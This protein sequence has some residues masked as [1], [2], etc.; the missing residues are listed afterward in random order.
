MFR[1]Q[2]WQRSL[3]FEYPFTISKGTKTH[4]PT[5]IVELTF[6]GIKGYGESPAISYYNISTEKMAADLESKRKF[7]ESYNLT[8]PK[9]FWHFLHHLFPDN[10][11]LVCALDMAAWDIYG[12]LNGKPLYAIWNLDPQNAPHT[13]YTIGIDDIDIML[14][15]I[16]EHPAPIYKIK[17]GNDQDMDK[18]RIIREHTQ[19][20]MRIDAN[21]GWS[22]DQAK[23]Y[24]PSLESMQIELIEQPLEKE[25]WIGHRELKELSSIPIIADESCVGE[26][27]IQQCCESFDGINIKLTKCSGI[28]PA[29]RMISEARKLNM[30]VMLGCMNESSIGTA[31]LA[32]LAP[33]VD[34]LDADGPLLLKEDLTNKSVYNDFRLIPNAEKGLGVLVTL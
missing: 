29:L 9:R 14:K 6:R 30:K 27:D 12:K 16:D 3:A 32:H 15:K 23:S 22:F 26:K 10:P 21:A 25:N 34:Y 1:V 17:V 11:F 24:L 4:Q 19:A 8:D 18:L 7:I 31:A 33:L 13:D 28:S 2:H 5:F 20:V